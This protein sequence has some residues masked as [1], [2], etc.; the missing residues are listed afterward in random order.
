MPEYDLS[1]ANHGQLLKR[2]FH[3]GI[4]EDVHVI[5]QR[6][7]LF[8]QLERPGYPADHFIDRNVVAAFAD[9]LRDTCLVERGVA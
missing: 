3:A 8:D 2:I 4:V 6:Q 1:I 5:A 9:T 7:R